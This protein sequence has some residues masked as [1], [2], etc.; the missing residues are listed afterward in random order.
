MEVRFGIRC[1]SPRDLGLARN[2]LHPKPLSA[3]AMR[4]LN[5][6]SEGIL[7]TAV[8]NGSFEEAWDTIAKMVPCWHPF[9]EVHDMNLF[10][11]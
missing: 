11:C 4:A 2:P 3:Y 7:N 6:K 5:L 1:L 8:N 9:L 10:G